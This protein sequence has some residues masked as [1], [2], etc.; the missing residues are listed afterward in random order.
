[1]AIKVFVAIS[2]FLI[3]FEKKRIKNKFSWENDDTQNYTL[4]RLQ[5][6]VETIGPSTSLTNQSKVYK[7]PQSC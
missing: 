7:G 6:M 1:M 2:Y 3:S 5:L 4:C